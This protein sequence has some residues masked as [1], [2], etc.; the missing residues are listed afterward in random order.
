MG[1]T[2][3]ACLVVKD[4]ANR[5]V[6]CLDP[7]IRQVDEVV[8]IDTG[9]SDGTPEIIRRRYG[10]EVLHGALEEARCFSKSDLRNAAFD[11][12]RTDWI[13]SIDAD[14]RLSPD[15]LAGFRTMRHPDGV[16]GYFGRWRN[17]VGD[18]P[19]FDDYKCF[20]FRR[21][22][23]M[24]G[25]VHE[26][27]QVDIRMRGGR[28]EWL[29]SLVVEHFPEYI[30]H[31]AKTESYG[32]RLAAAMALEPHWHRYHWFSGYLH[33]QLG[34]YDRAFAEL[35]IAFESGNPLFPVERLNSGMVLVDLLCRSGRE[36]EA[37]DMVQAVRSL[38]QQVKD[39]FEVRVNDGLEPWIQRTTDLLRTGRA[40]EVVTNRFAR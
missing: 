31:A 9:S 29:D 10:I 25:L 12:V 24:R 1:A 39:D 20:L 19:P 17:W 14:E 3:A 4:E 22:F 15:G 23:R 2:L 32:R 38:W 36:C 21:G 33:A 26:N 37:L 34:R 13:L 16:S 30:K 40:H 7:L 5:I 8:V 27:A 11:T 28:A 35:R 18:D 6:E